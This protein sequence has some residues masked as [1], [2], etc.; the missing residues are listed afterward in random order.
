MN[1]KLSFNYIVFSI[2]R[3]LNSVAGSDGY[4]EKKA[5]W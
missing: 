4:Y 3:L 5:N 1:K 2:R